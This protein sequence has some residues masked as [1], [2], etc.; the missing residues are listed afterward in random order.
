MKLTQKDK[1]LILF[2]SAALVVLWG[3]YTLL[4]SVFF[5]ATFHI[6]DVKKITISENKEWF[7]VSRPLQ[8]SDLKDR[9]VLVHFW[10]YACVS[11]IE[12]LPQLKELENE[13]GD[14][15]VII[16]VHSAK[17]DN[18]KNYD[19]IKKAI[20]KYDITHPV[21]NDSALKVWD[22][23][24]VKAWPTFLLI[25][26]HGNIEKTY[27]GDSE[28]KN[29]INDTKE[30]VD[31]NK[32]K[33]NRDPLPTLLEK[34]NVIKNVLNF[35]TKL[36]YAPTLTYK[37]R[38]IPAIFIA[39]TGQHNII[40]SSLS[41]DVIVKIGSGKEG[42]IDGSFDVA[43][44]RY[45]RGLLFSGN[46]LY[47]ADSGNHAIRVIDFKEGR[48]ETLVGSGVRG[49]VIEN[50]AFL[51]ALKVN[52][53]SPNDLEFF[54][55]KNTIA[56]S[57][58]GTNQ[59]LGYNLKRGT[60]SVLAGNGAEGIEDGKYP[61]NSLAQTGDMS[62]FGR[63]LYFLDALTSSLRVLDEAGNVKTLIG[64]SAK[65]GHENGDKNKALMQSPLGLNV[66]DTGAYISD[67]LNH[68][69]RK[70]DFSSGQIRD[71][72]GGKK[73]DEIGAK[74]RFDEPE[75]IITVLD[76]FYVADSNNNRILM[77]SRGSLNSEILDVMPPLKLPREGFLQYLPNLQK[78]EEVKIKADSEI[79]VKIDLKPGWKINELGPSFINLLQ[80]VKDDQANLIASFDWNSVKGKE[81]KLSKLPEGEDYILQGTIY[82]CEDKKN[83]LCY[84]KS[85]EQ[86]II[87]DDDEKTAEIVIKLGN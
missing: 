68:M 44:F 6:S 75:G 62:A 56:I 49:D 61:E 16:G 20:L 84:V 65:F 66:D 22:S 30:L 7:N 43:S 64:K 57:N 36:E 85:Y 3:V 54:P 40:A 59:I 10:T 21:V 51:E 55:D 8:A 37:T 24:G 25:N 47:V 28:I 50:E 60:I 83:A 87:A 29:L 12:T 38:Q 80:L 32:Y 74:T 78:S 58:S 26:A 1:S 9:I 72:V 4:T 34:Y 2:V 45:P 82:Y 69:I 77:I 48:V 33:I 35:P 11:C 73:G 15:L 79:F 81:M 86:K 52:L 71:L 27:V 41:G 5:A 13:L 23:F 70:Y 39:N 63:K 53:A 14:K 42:F 67:S 19:S 17:F 31:D 18:E 76:R 46:K